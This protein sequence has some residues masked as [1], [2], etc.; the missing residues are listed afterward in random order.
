L[1]LAR[2][3]ATDMVS[4]REWQDDVLAA[5]A[6]RLEQDTVVKNQYTLARPSLKTLLQPW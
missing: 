6:L 1:L 3:G 2:E 5:E 4:A